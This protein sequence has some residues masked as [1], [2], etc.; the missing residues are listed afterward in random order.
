MLQLAFHRQG[1]V[2]IGFHQ[3]ENCQS[4]GQNNCRCLKQK[5]PRYI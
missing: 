2:S 4:V 1:N 3:N 5:N